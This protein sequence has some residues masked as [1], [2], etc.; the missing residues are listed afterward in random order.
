MRTRWVALVLTVGL[1][2]AG[3]AGSPS[4]EMPPPLRVDPALVAQ[5]EA[6]GI[7]DCPE[8]PVAAT[9]V[10]DGLPDLLLPCL[11]SSR[12]V[13]LAALRGQP[14]VVNLWAQWC[15]PCR[16]EAPH[17]TEFARLAGERV[18]VLG[19]DYDDPD[20][21]LALE[22]AEHAGWPYAHV[23]DPLKRTAG[24]LRVQGLPITLLVD[25][26]GRIVHRTVGPIASLEA[27]VA[28][29]E[30]HLGVQL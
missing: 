23:S 28:D 10:R 21:A 13:N 2:L 4:D 30:T 6:A 22:F 19:L 8:T 5:R 17:L 26:E 9:P 3:C 29:V 16:E 11:G 14:M 25:A 27:L 1:A 15:G 24:S 18:Q 7:P 20:P 12:Q